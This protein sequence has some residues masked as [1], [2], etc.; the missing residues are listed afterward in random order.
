MMQWDSLALGRPR[1]RQLSDRLLSILHSYHRAAWHNT[2]GWHRCSL[3]G[4][5]SWHCWFNDQT[6]WCRLGRC[7][8]QFGVWRQSN[9]GGNHIIV[10]YRSVCCAGKAAQPIQS[11]LNNVSLWTRWSWLWSFNLT[12]IPLQITKSSQFSVMFQLLTATCSRSTLNFTIWNQSIS[13]IYYNYC[14]V[15]CT[16]KVQRHSCWKFDIYTCSKKSITFY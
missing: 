2:T 9:I 10:S 8:R 7:K 11:A 15:K 4:F 12:R 6:L 3:V 1:C 5:S 14:N 13:M 16:A